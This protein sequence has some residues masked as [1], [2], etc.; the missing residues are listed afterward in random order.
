MRLDLDRYD[1]LLFD[2]D[3]VVLESNA[4][5][6]QAF[7]QLFAEQPEVVR[8]RVLQLHRANPGRDRTDKVRRC[9][10]EILGYDPSP[11]ELHARLQLFHELSLRLSLA[12]PPVTGVLSFVAKLPGDIGRYI[13]S[14][15]RHDE[16][17]LIANKKGVHQLFDGVYGSPPDKRALIN[18]ILEAEQAA[19]SRTLL[20][21]D[22]ISDLTA[23]RGNGIAFIGRIGPDAVKAFP[24]GTPTFKEF[25]ELQLRGL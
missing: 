24:H 9:F 19:P 5:K 13:V 23:A 8:R 16:V 6:D 14:A 20:I 2:F 7:H 25:T 18:R 15:S 10:N 3:G 11:Q 4:A 17:N 22:K 1:L 12:C 21:G